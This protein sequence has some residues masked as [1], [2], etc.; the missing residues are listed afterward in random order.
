[1]TNIVPI[2]FAFDNNVM[3][4]ACVCLSSL[5]MS[6]DN[7]TFYD[8]FIC[9]K[10]DPHFQKEHIDK[11]TNTY[12]MCRIRY[13]FVD[14]SFDSAYEVRHVTKATYY[15]L[16]LPELI[17]E[18][19]KILYSDI[20]IIFRMDLS[21]VYNQDLTDYYIAATYDLGINQDTKYINSLGL[22]KWEYYQAGFLLL[23]LKELR[24]NH[25]VDK[26][27]KFSRNKF[28]YQD[29]DI[30]NICCKGKI[31]QLAPCYN[32]NDCAFIYIYKHQRILP[33]TINSQDCD[34]ALK[35]G[36]IHY[37]GYKPWNR[38]SICFDIWWEYYRKSPFFN[39]REYFKFFLDKT[40]LL[41]SLTL[42]KRI[43]NLL[44]YFVYGRYK[45]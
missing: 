24:K 37:S 35:N 15:R 22:E 36:N 26:F 5:M 42:W 41:D 2:A 29:Q 7:N 23:N 28:L 38:Y 44:R 9:C 12:P 43:K 27:K 17:K 34:Y 31:K 11:I 1:M 10:R 3:K 40:M 8:I 33:E 14:E 13:I 6:A 25:I 16:L 4:A 18:Y 39:D 21:G 20:D 30:L 45:D 19:D 32:M